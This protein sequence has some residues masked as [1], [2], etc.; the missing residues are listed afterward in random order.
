M[1]GHGQLKLI[2][3][4]IDRCLHGRSTM[5]WYGIKASLKTCKVSLDS[6]SELLWFIVRVIVSGY[7]RTC[8]MHRQQ[9]KHGKGIEASK[10]RLS[11]SKRL[12]GN[13]Y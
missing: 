6:L 12:I 3:Q 10:K 11:C 13:A 8:A 4:V 2:L 7:S 9:A 5:R 1:L